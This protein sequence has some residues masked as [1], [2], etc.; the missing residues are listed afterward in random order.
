MNRNGGV[1]HVLYRKPH[2]LKLEFNSKWWHTLTMALWSRLFKRF[3]YIFK[4]TYMYITSAWLFPNQSQI[5][6]WK[7][8]TILTGYTALAR[9][10]KEWWNIKRKQC[11]LIFVMVVLLR[12]MVFSFTVCNNSFPRIIFLYR[13]S[14]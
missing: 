12:N 11:S 13:F 8:L 1:V 7:F 6:I 3:C 14:F 10:K 2:K 4:N 9:S 5:Y